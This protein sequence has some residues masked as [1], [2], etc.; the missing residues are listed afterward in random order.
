MGDWAVDTHHF[1]PFNV[2]ISI[3]DRPFCTSHQELEDLYEQLLDSGLAWM[4]V[5][6]YGFSKRIGWVNDRY[7]V[8]WQLNVT[9]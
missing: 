8:S 1:L 9:Y 2:K 6:E 7:G 4:L 5:G 3:F